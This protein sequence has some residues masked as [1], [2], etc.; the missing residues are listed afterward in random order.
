MTR[1]VAMT[2]HFVPTDLD[3]LMKFSRIIAASHLVPKE[4]K[5]NWENVFVAIIYGQSL[6][7]H[8]LQSIQNIS[9]I[10]GRPAVWGDALLAIVL[11]HPDCQGVEEEFQEYGKG[12]IRAI[13]R[14]KRRG[15]K[16]VVE[17]FTQDNALRSGLWNKEG[18]WQTYPERMLKMRARGFALRDAFADALN[19]IITAEEAMDIPQDNGR[20]LKNEI[21]NGDAAE[22]SILAPASEEGALCDVLSR[23]KSASTIGELDDVIDAAK[24]L[25]ETSRNAARDAFRER[26]E[27]L[28]SASGSSSLM[29]ELAD[30][31]EKE[32]THAA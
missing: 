16:D 11:A 25:D 29:D 17:I 32:E 2:N 1:A 18:A 30:E 21:T 24:S 3:G 7:L 13:C 5:G 9:V 10:N 14:V 12:K 6:G 23:I 26:R 31:I 15:R 19:G 28:A 8:P 22:V 20:S 4:Y 27:E